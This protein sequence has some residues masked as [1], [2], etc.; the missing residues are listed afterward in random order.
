MELKVIK[1]METDSE[2]TYGRNELGEGEKK[3]IRERAS[4]YMIDR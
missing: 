1:A 2:C 3:V 4:I